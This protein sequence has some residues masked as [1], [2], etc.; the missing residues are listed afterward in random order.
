MAAT[1]RIVSGLRWRNDWRSQ[2]DDKNA[3]RE[4]GQKKHCLNG[5]PGRLLLI[6]L[7]KLR[8]IPIFSPPPLAVINA[9]AATALL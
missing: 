4:K 6:E 3:N 9:T 5:K 1:A 7:R 2:L 8:G